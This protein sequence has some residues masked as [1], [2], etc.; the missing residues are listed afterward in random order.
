M[1]KTVKQACRFNPVIHDYRMAQG[2]ENLADLI[3]HQGDGR[4]FFAR[5]YVTQGMEQLFRE[6][7]L[8]LSGKSDQAVFELNQAMGG[9][10][11]LRVVTTHPDRFGYAAVW[12]AGL[13]GGSAAEFEKR[14]AAFFKGADKVNQSVRLL[15]VSVGEKDFALFQLMRV[16]EILQVFADDD[17]VRERAQVELQ[18]LDRAP[19]PRISQRSLEQHIFTSA[20]R[21]IR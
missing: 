18:V 14:N 5:N 20:E 21:L 7:M 3:G 8:R 6:G 17:E 13:F 12:S 16:D 1:M 15:S 11:T 9:G 4:E 19:R 10:K 2:I